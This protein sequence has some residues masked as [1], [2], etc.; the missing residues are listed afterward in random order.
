MVANSA[1][2]PMRKS[3][4]PTWRV[5]LNIAK[6]LAA[7][8]VLF[9]DRFLKNM[10]CWRDFGRVNVFWRRG[11]FDPE[12]CGRGKEKPLVVLKAGSAELFGSGENGMGGFGER[13]TH[14]RGLVLAAEE[15]DR[16]NTF[17][18]VNI[19]KDVKDTES[20][21]VKEGSWVERL[22]TGQ[23]VNHLNSLEKW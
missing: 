17:H 12:E 16:K 5:I 13:L 20:F 21:K 14:R 1:S 19:K 7:V 3:G 23:K 2:G 6:C 10:E 22:S 9:G 11:F 15:S 4:L 8:G 18:Q